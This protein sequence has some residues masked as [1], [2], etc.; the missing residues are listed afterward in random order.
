MNSDPETSSSTIETR[1][2][3]SSTLRL[4]PVRSA[5]LA[6]VLLSTASWIGIALLA[7]SLPTA[8][9]RLLGL[10]FICLFVLFLLFLGSLFRRQLNEI[11][12]FI[13]VWAVVLFPFYGSEAPFLWLR[14]EAFRIH[15]SPLEQYLSQCKLI[16]FVENGAR[17]VLGRCDNLATGGEAVF[18]VFYDS[19]GEFVLPVSQRSSEWKAA[20]SHFSPHEVLINAEGRAHKLSEKFYGITIFPGE[21]DGDDERY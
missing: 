13:A 3:L 2:A 4:K 9:D 11:L 18:D 10:Y 6:L 17:Q 8:P 7:F 15:T 1:D 21:Y 16:E 5:I 20:M 14:A 12:I 19:T